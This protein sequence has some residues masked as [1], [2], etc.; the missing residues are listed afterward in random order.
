MH[1]WICEPQ[2]TVKFADGSNAELR[3]IAKRL[4]VPL[5]GDEGRGPQNGGLSLCCEKPE[6]ER[7]LLAFLCTVQQSSQHFFLEAVLQSDTARNVFGAEAEETGILRLTTHN[8][9]ELITWV[10]YR[11]SALE[12]KVP[13]DFDTFVRYGRIPAGGSVAD[14]AIEAGR[15]KRRR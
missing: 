15:A 4:G 11:T 10:Y 3:Q 8:I 9:Y 7:R 2:I 6:A 13:N 1:S 14:T 5:Y 12:M